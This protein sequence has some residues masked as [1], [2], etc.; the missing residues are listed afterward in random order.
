M[1]VHGWSAPEV[2]EV[3]ERA[4]EIGRRLE[5]SAELAPAIANLWIFNMGRGRIDRADEISADLFRMA[6]ELGDD[7]I[8][9]QAHHCAW[10]T[11]FF[12]GR[13]KEAAEHVAAGAALY[14]AERH[15]HHRHL[16]LG[17]DPRICSMN[18]GASASVALGYPD[19]AQ[20]LAIDGIAAARELAHPPSLGNALWRACE[21]FAMREDV[22]TVRSTATE[23]I[24]LTDVHGLPQPRVHA[25]SYLGWALTRSGERAEGLALLL[26]GERQLIAMA[27]LVHATFVLG[28]RADGLLAAGLYAE[29]LEQ[30]DRALAVAAEGGEHVYLAPLHRLRAKIA[31]RLRGAGDPA[32]EASLQQALAIAQQQE[33]KGSSWAPP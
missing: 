15:A 30:I 11:R 13:V 23:L 10:A 21:V 16:Y 19:R 31:V 29:G 20:R 6:D 4:A 7:D 17:H 5:S 32:A 12:Q 25:F 2:G 26:E 9:L 33:T 27:A 18:F 24:K 22:E 1:G 8:R 14:N 3:V 28:L